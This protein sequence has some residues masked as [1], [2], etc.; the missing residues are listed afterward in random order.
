MAYANLYLDITL[1]FP[2]QENLQ[3]IPHWYVLKL[4]SI[5]LQFSHSTL[6]LL[7]LYSTLSLSFVSPLSSLPKHLSVTD[8]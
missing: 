8:Y 7:S 6:V 4:K 1:Y 3:I 2:T 5:P